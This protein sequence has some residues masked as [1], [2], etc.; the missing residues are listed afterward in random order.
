MSKITNE[1]I[2]NLFAFS[3]CNQQGHQY[4]YLQ[5]AAA[6]VNTEPIGDPL[7][8]T[9]TFN[10]KKTTTTKTPKDNKFY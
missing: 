5:P 7:D 2:C 8:K 10:T 9:T 6:L 1:I 4:P 3:T